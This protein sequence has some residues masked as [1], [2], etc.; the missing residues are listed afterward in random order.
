VSRFTRIGLVL[1]ASVAVAGALGPQVAAHA[2][3]DDT[4][5]LNYV[6]S[7]LT[8][9]GLVT[10]ALESTTP[11]NGL[12]ADVEGPDDNVV[13]SLPLA[14]FSAPS[15]S[16]NYSTWTL[17]KAITMSQ[18]PLG[19]YTV[20]VQ[21][22][23]TGGGS[24]TGTTTGTLNFLAWPT[25]SPNAEQWS[26]QGPESEQQ[27]YSGSVIANEPGGGTVPDAGAT[28]T[29]TDYLNNPATFTATTDSSGSYQFVLTDPPPDQAFGYSIYVPA[30]PTNGGGLYQE[31]TGS[32]TAG[33]LILAEF[34]PP[35]V[36]NGGTS[37]LSGTVY[38]SNGT[39]YTDY[40]GATVTI[41][42]SQASTT[43]VTVT[44][45]TQGQ[46]SYT[47]P[48][49][50]QDT[51]WT[52]STPADGYIGAGSATAGL[53]INVPTSVTGF[54]ARLSPA[55]VLTLNAQVQPQPEDVSYEY[56]S[57]P[58]G[59][60]KLLGTARPDGAG[61][62]PASFAA[63]LA[64]GY[65][66]AQF[67]GGVGYDGS[68]SGVLHEWKYVTRISGFA[69]SP[70]RGSQGSEVK[71]SGVL[72]RDVN[73]WHPYAHQSITIYLVR[74]SKIY[75]YKHRLTTDGSGKFSGRL[76]LVYTGKMLAQFNGNDSFFGVDSRSVKVTVSAGAAL[77]SAAR[78]ARQLAATAAVPLSAAAALGREIDDLYL[79]SARAQGFLTRL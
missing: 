79:A 5:T 49:Q 68:V 60:W 67:G 28:L 63:P 4:I 15:T 53:L 62:D 41:A 20:A 22:T 50:T 58:N 66:R 29:V 17:T 54:A 45:N 52:I 13:L 12:T 35:S 44:T 9:P 2:Q 11:I 26:V 70:A 77:R 73:G 8:N 61:A 16:G 21:A 74:G 14:A 39:A 48:A 72:A 32:N 3:G 30:T 19:T 6:S 18:L 24:M 69:V 55:G 38:Y 36:D 10:I 37:T 71:V 7:P 1:A 34:T 42:S 27:T 33:V 25:L 46:F 43:P 51:T 23:D 64:N 56:A 76:P 57:A 65:Y 31:T 40:A 47:T 78:A 75:Y 59:P